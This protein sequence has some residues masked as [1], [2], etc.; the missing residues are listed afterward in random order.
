MYL[1]HSPIN[2]SVIYLETNFALFSIPNYEG[3]A[4]IPVQ[5]C[6][7]T[8][9]FLSNLGTYLTLKFFFPTKDQ[10]SISF[11]SV[12]KLFF[13]N[14]SGIFHTS[15]IF[16]LHQSSKIRHYIKSK[17]MIIKGK[18]VINSLPFCTSSP[19]S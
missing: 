13:T 8:S 3:I 11:G 17:D 10:R 7:C 9:S 1:S 15:V 4:S 19:K 16:K 5:N 18:K 2:K 14:H 6:P 12:P